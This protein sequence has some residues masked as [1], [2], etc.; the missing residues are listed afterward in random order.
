MRSAFLA[1]LVML[2]AAPVRAERIRSFEVEIELAGDDRF[3]VV[4]TIVYDF[5]GES[6]HG[7]FREIPVAY[8]RGRAADYHIGLDVDSVTD[9]AGSDRTRSLSSDRGH[10]RIRIGDPDRYVTGVQTYEIRY[11]VRRGILWFESHDELYWNV[12]GTQW[13]VPI[14]SVRASVR[15]ASGA[16]LFDAQRGCFTGSLGSVESACTASARGQRVEFEGT[17]PLGPSEGLTL[18]LGLQKGVLE[19]PSR[20]QMIMDRAR[21]YLSAWLLLPLWV[22]AAMILLWRRVGRDVGRREAVPVCYEP[23]EGLTPAEAGTLLDERADIEDITATIL[24]LAVRGHIEIE[25]VETPS[26]LFLSS[27]DYRLGLRADLGPDA[28]AHERALVEGL[29][30]GE[31]SVK[32]STLREKFYKRLPAIQRSLYKELTGRGLFPASPERVRSLWRVAGGSILAAGG[33]VLF[34]LE[35]TLAGACI[36]LSGAIVMA[37]AGAMPRRTRQGTRVYEEL[38]GLREFVDRVDRDRLERT[39]GLDE[40]R[41]EQILP[42][43]VVLGVA[44]RWA[45]AFANIYTK[46]PDWY[47]GSQHELFEPRIFVSNVGRGLQTIG[48][49]LASAPRSQGSGSSGFSSGGGSGGGFGGGGGG[50]W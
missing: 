41:F 48:Q 28:R 45:D 47:H 34:S 26:F 16:T 4:E 50:S 13:P 3:Q 19:E 22:L 49:T 38:L 36:G 46:P 35:R 39:G 6:R 17:R 10:L 11:R 44:D 29:F 15:L 40:G 23:P 5:E 43:A 42:Y 33:I 9:G 32:I 31:R 14:D 20:A 7:I 18:V 12:T 24:D 37:F 30:S 21:D 2:L 1:V 8:G 25:E 27:V